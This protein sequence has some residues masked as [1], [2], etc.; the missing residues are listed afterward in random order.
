MEEKQKRCIAMRKRTDHCL[1]DHQR[2][3]VKSNK[4]SQE[5]SSLYGALFSCS[6][7]LYTFFTSS[8]K[9]TRTSRSCVHDAPVITRRPCE[10]RHTGMLLSLQLFP[11]RRKTAEENW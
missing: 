3:T 11:K 1:S 4:A 8:K 10:T 7:V 2:K 9:R 5:T 6:S